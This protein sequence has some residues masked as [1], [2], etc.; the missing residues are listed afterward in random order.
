MYNDV[1]FH[2]G[3]IHMIRTATAEDAHLVHKIMTSAFEEY[4]NCDVP[5]GALSET[6]ESIGEAL[7]NGT[8]MALICYKDGV[9][10]GTVRFKD[11][12]DSL[13]FFRLSV[14][15]EA[16]RQGLAKSML[17]WLEN[18][19]REQGLKEVRCS[20][21]KSVP[22]NIQLYQ[23]VGFTVRGEKTV[24]NSNGFTV[25]IV[26]MSKEIGKV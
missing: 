12:G 18:Y 9:P 26:M 25:D 22:R 20:V 7:R 2:S 17:A 14:V 5:S 19:A 4:G 24:T 21:R 3:V 13:Y 6:A 15:P 11:D 8:E 16:R 23:S 10:A 1:S